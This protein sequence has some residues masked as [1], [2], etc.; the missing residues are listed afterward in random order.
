MSIRHFI[1]LVESAFKKVETEYGIEVKVWNQPTA[2]T[3]RRLLASWKHGARGLVYDDRI[4]L[5]NAEE[6]IHADIAYLLRPDDVWGGFAVVPEG[7]DLVTG[8]Y[9]MDE[10]AGVWPTHDG[11][12]VYFNS[13]PEDKARVL[14]MFPEPK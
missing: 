9:D 13:S 7:D 8:E 5:W 6:A 3:A 11:Y 1:D 4:F 10:Q 2:M 12:M 14:A